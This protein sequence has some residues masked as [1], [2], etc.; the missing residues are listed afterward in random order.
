MG[1]FNKLDADRSNLVT[2][3]EFMRFWETYAFRAALF[4][5]LDVNKDGFL[6]QKEVQD[7]V[8]K[9]SLA[10]TLGMS[11]RESR[12]WGHDKLGWKGV[13]DKL[14]AD[15]S[16]SV[17]KAEFV[18]AWCDARAKSKPLSLRS[19]AASLTFASKLKKMRSGSSPDELFD[20]IDTDGSGQLSPTKQAMRKMNPFYWMKGG[21]NKGKK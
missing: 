7:G 1:V 17:T 8:L 6:S 10:E 20:S 13:F 14:D 15:Q 9:D 11:K 4:D 18:Q 16:N 2:K 3:D 5:R 21:R 19:A 12:F